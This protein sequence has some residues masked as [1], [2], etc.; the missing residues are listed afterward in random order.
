MEKKTYA[1]DDVFG[2]MFFVQREY[3]YKMAKE[4]DNVIK[5]TRAKNIQEYYEDYKLANE[6]GAPFNYIDEIP[7]DVKTDM[8]FYYSFNA[9]R[10]TQDNFEHFMRKITEGCKL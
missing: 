4:I 10:L 6:I 3:H 1:K 5:K 9:I 2:L 8:I 7:S